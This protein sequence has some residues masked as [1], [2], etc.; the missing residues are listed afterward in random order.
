MPNQ[1]ILNSSFLKNL[2]RNSK[3][4]TETKKMKQ[5]P[6][7]TACETIR[8][9][10]NDLDVKRVFVVFFQTLDSLPPSTTR[11]HEFVAM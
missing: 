11:P 7:P 5:N 2:Y 1:K 8:H 3:L 6:I 10:M 9:K 4:R